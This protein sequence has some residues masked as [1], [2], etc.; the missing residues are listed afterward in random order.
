[1]EYTDPLVRVSTVAAAPTSYSA[2]YHRTPTYSGRVV[3]DT[4]VDI[5]NLAPLLPPKDIAQKVEL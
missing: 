1:M 5:E 3:E 2:S 4:D